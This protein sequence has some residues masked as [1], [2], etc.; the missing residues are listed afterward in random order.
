MEN[1][2]LIIAGAAL[3]GLVLGFLIKLI[4]VRLSIRSVKDEAERIIGVARESAR[5]LKFRQKIRL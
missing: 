4:Q 5:E 2:L 1:Q 3:V